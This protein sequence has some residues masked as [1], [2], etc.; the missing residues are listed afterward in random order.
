MLLVEL[1]GILHRM[2]ILGFRNFNAAIVS[3]VEGTELVDTPRCAM[4]L[5]LT[6]PALNKLQFLALKTQQLVQFLSL[7]LSPF[8]TCL[9]RSYLQDEKRFGRFA[10][11]SIRNFA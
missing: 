1:W 9:L 4:I 6:V 11:E 3:C 10:V 8:S 7:S 2:V 5:R